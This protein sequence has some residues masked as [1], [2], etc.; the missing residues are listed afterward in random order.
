L[1]PEFESRV[2][3]TLVVID[4]FYGLW[5]SSSINNAILAQGNSLRDLSRFLEWSV[6][7]IEDYVVGQRY[8]WS[9][10]GQKLNWE[11]AVSEIL[12]LWWPLET[13]FFL[14][15]ISGGTMRAWGIHLSSGTSWLIFLL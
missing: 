7:W 1:R 5:S 6:L 3:D 13:E 12:L 14:W 2:G 4:F 11:L 10:F 9:K 15:T 8:F